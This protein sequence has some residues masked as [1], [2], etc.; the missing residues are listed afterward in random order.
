MGALYDYFD[1]VQVNQLKDELSITVIGTEESGL[2]FL[3]NVDSNH[4]YVTWIASDGEVFY[5]THADATQMENHFD[6][7]EMQEALHSGMG[8]AY[9]RSATLLE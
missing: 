4:F 5:D 3:K 7:E 6:R 1:A 2:D 9:R 8:S